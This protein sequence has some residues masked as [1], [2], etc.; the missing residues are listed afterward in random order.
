[1]P[2]KVKRNPYLLI[3]VLGYLILYRDGII[4]I[5]IGLVLE[6]LDFGR[7]FPSVDSHSGLGLAWLSHDTPS[8]ISSAP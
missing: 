5:E 1:M 8:R 6:I 7:V 2:Y 4:N 3:I